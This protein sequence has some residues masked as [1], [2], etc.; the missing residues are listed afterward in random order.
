MDKFIEYFDSN[1]LRVL[2]RDGGWE[3]ILEVL[4]FFLHFIV[5]FGQNEIRV[6]PDSSVQ[7]FQNF[8]IPNTRNIRILIQNGGLAFVASCSLHVF[9]HFQKHLWQR[10]VRKS[11]LVHE[12]RHLGNQLHKMVEVQGGQILPLDVFKIKEPHQCLDMILGYLVQRE[13]VFL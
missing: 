2:D 1:T 13:S 9:N 10:Q 3:L 7:L 12:E 8:L 5:A 6:V 4:F 11:P